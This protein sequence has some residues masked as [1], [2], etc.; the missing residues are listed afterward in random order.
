[1]HRAVYRGERRVGSGNPDR[2]YAIAIAAPGS[3]SRFASRYL[4]CGRQAP[5]RAR[6]A[7][8]ENAVRTLF[9]KFH[10]T[11][12]PHTVRKGPPDPINFEDAPRPNLRT[13]YGK[14]A[15]HSF[16]ALGCI[17]PRR[18]LNLV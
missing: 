1:V 10:E 17:K 8:D 16:P 7:S 2:R 4:G 3:V 11:R 6:N 5:T 13:R 14:V 9:Q 15:G 12:L 18:G